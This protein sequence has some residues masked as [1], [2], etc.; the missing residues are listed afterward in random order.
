M[1]SKQYLNVVVEDVLSEAVM[2]RLLAK[3][4]YIGNPPTFRIARGNSMI[5][6]NLDKYKGASRV[7]PHIVLTD[8]D[9]Y[10]C[11]TALLADWRVGALPPTMLLRIAVREVE[12]WLLADRKG[13]A[14]FLH[15]A[16][17]KVPLSPESIDDAKQALFNVIR[18]SRRRRLVEEMIP[19]PGAH[20]GP[21]YNDRMRNFAL[22]CW[23]IETAAANAPSLD[24]SILRIAAFL[25]NG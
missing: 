7:I 23:R 25:A 4:G 8:L 20:I 18:K 1:S 10:P 2:L 19:Q 9:R 13:I 14:D 24:R 5:R 22:N 11:P 6:T 16:I 15:V 3:A 12:A 21:L 17:E